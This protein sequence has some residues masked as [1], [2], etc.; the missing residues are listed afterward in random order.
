MAKAVMKFGK[1]QMRTVMGKIK[2][3]SWYDRVKLKYGGKG[4]EEELKNNPKS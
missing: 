3:K 2:T 4:L 1:N